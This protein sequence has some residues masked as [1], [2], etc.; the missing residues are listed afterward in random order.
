MTIVAGVYMLLVVGLI[1]V[2]LFGGKLGIKSD[3]PAEILCILLGVFLIRDAV[4]G[5]QTVTLDVHL[6]ALFVGLIITA[7]GALGLFSDLYTHFNGDG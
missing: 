7:I 5:F 2:T 1:A 3:I 6:A 4:I